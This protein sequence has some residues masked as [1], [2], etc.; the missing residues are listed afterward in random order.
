MRAAARLSAAAESRNGTTVVPMAQVL[1]G[2]MGASSK[3]K[4]H[5]TKPIWTQSSCFRNFGGM[6]N[7]AIGLNICTNI[8]AQ[9]PMRTQ[10]FTVG[11]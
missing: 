4:Q 8:L 7:L 10:Q 6:F 5:Q 1:Q 9:P 11:P 2:T 3:H